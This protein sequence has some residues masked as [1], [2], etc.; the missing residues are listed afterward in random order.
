MCRWT[1]CSMSRSY[2]N[3]H[4]REHFVYRAYDAAGRLLY[5]GCTRRPI[6]RWKQHRKMGGWAD[7]AVRFHVAG[8]YNYD[9]GRYLERHGIRTENPRHNRDTAEEA[10]ARRERRQLFDELTD[11]WLGY[12]VDL[13]TA[14]NMA[15]A[16]A[17]EVERVQREGEP[18][19]QVA[20]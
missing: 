1:E 7:D 2:D 16:I 13:S 4:C 9:T 19:E 15:A 5:V 8:P 10:R 14:M 17:D 20:S 18:G 12:G 3:P 6:A 11:E